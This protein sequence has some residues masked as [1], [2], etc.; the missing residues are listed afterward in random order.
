MNLQQY[1]ALTCKTMELKFPYGFF[2]NHRTEAKRQ[3]LR[4]EFKGRLYLKIAHCLRLRGLQRQFLIKFTAQTRRR[5][6]DSPIG[7]KIC[8]RFCFAR[9]PSTTHWLHYSIA[10]LFGMPSKWAPWFPDGKLTLS[11]A[12]RSCFRQG[13]SLQDGFEARRRAK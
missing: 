3:S 10:V 6:Y 13:N 11:L 2:T 12:P 9:R 1:P 7:R 5:G 4:S 8:F